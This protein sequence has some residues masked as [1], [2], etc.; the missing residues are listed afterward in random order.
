MTTIS[1]GILQALHDQKA[2]REKEKEEKEDRKRKRVTTQATKR[3]R[4]TIVS[5]DEESQNPDTSDDEPSDAEIDMVPPTQSQRNT[6]QPCNNGSLFDPKADNP[7][8][9][10]LEQSETAPPKDPRPPPKPGHTDID[11]PLPQ[12][13]NEKKN[14]RWSAKSLYQKD[15]FN[16]DQIS[17][18]LCCGQCEVNSCNCPRHHHRQLRAQ[19]L[20]QYPHN[21]RLRNALNPHQL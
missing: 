17:N 16:G 3:K 4:A 11:L 8:I 21:L 2:E 9:I 19:G 12:F 14:E 20:R 13:A 7:T 1:S 10:P 15:G 18:S 6:K 5:S